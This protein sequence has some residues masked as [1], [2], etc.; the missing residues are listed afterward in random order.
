[1]YVGNI[2]FIERSLVLVRAQA[3]RDEGYDVI[4]REK[5]SGLNNRQSDLRIVVVSSKNK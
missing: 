2:R 5:V 4:R 1:M 3:L